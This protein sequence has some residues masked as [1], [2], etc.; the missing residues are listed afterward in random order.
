MNAAEIEA[1]TE[2]LG[3]EIYDVIWNLLDLAEM[4]GVDLEAAFFAKKAA[5]N[6]DR[7]W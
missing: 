4:A 5:L 3:T 7:E 2:N 1:V 6:K